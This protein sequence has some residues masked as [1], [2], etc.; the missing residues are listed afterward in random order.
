M[1]RNKETK[2]NIIFSLVQQLTMA[3]VG[4]I[5]PRMILIHYGTE[6]NGLMQAIGQILS[7]TVMLE[8]GIGGVILASFYKPLAKGDDEAVSDIFNYVKSYFS[9]ISLIYFGFTALLCVGGYYLITSD[10]SFL[11]VS[12]MVAILGLSNYITYYFAL[13]H[14]LLIKADRKIRIINAV[15]IITSLANLLV[16]WILMEKG[17]GLHVVKFVSAGVFLINPLVLRLYVKKNYKIEKAY[18]NKEREFPKK[19]DGVVHHLSYFV[20]ENTDIVLIS[21]VLGAA[22]VSVYSVYNAVLIVIKNTLNSVCSGISGTIG[23]IIA[24]GEKESLE[25]EFKKYECLNTA[26]TFGIFTVCLILILPFVSIYTK[27]VEDAEYIRPVFALF[28]VLGGLMYCVRIPYA[29][30]ISSAGHYKETK[31]GALVEVII[32]LVISVLLI[33]PLGMVGVAVG[34]F[35]AMAYRT[36]YT[37]WYLSGNI[38]KR[39]SRK[40]YISFGVNFLAGFLAVYLLKGYVYMKP[41]SLWQ[42]FCVGLRLSL[43]VF[44]LFFAINI[45]MSYGRKFLRK[46]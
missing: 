40:F 17:L 19:R 18:Y 29:T 23:N 36:G 27:G 8:F 4:L 28:A 26:L 32:N 3:V 45:M 5:L 37:V 10:F 7:Y 14:Q 43:V 41:E 9:K 30:V 16:C 44:P 22:S 33:K 15:Q 21:M 25:K 42:F 34:T 20:H 35:L 39:K 6:A 11:Y 2:L 1:E 12:T 24:K 38:L 46:N 31:K 13:S